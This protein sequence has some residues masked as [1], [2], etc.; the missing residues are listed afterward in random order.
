MFK[1]RRLK[2]NEKYVL[3]DSS[4]LLPD[5]RDAC[6]RVKCEGKV[7]QQHP[8]RGGQLDYLG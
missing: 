5:S 7:L 1:L 2:K 3:F 4:R 8:C 6:V